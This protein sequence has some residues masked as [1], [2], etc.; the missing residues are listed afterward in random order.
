MLVI[1]GT[2]VKFQ[3]AGAGTARDGRCPF[4]CVVLIEVLVVTSSLRFKGE[5]LDFVS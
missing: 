3:M 2:S 1:S 5:E 4:Y